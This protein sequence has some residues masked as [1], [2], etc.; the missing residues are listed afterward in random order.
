MQLQT[1]ININPRARA[2]YNSR[3]MMM[4]S[5]FA[6]NM[7]E[8]LLA[9]RFDTVLN[10]FGIL[11]N[12][13][14]IA[15]ALERL[16]ENRLFTKEELVE[17][18][19]MFSSFMHHGSFSAAE[20]DVTLENMNSSYEEATRALREIDT[21]IVT[22]GSSHIY[23]YEG[24]I[25]ANCHKMPA[26]MF[27]ERRM[28]IE[29]ICNI[30]SKTIA[31]IREINPSVEVIFS[32]SPVRYLGY[33]AKESQC[34]KATLLLAVE[35][36]CRKNDNAHYFP[37][38]E[39]MMDELRDYRFYKADMVHPNEIAIEYIWEKFTTYLFSKDT[40]K[41]MEE[42]EKVNRALSH[43]PLH[44]EGAEYK[45]FQKNTMEKIEALREK[46]PNIKL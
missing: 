12:P 37:A 42:V 2:S 32:V 9:S 38:Y 26:K 23:E 3:F 21:L 36:I 41:V 15:R 5:C 14:S 31:T 7:G 39:I 8:K 27:A 10:P 1:T 4:G 13:G 17:H 11:Y 35:N 40:H 19:G 34:N 22:F 30:W 20:A 44:A 16:A 45:T 24:D 29:E 46:Y 18:R 25:V 28:T 6:Q 33:G 43:R